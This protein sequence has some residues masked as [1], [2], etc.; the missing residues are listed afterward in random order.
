M[1]DEF[2][3]FETPKD[4]VGGLLGLEHGCLQVAGEG[5][6]PVAATALGLVE[7][8]VGI[9][10]DLRQVVGRLGLGCNADADADAAFLVLVANRNAHR[11]D[12]A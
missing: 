12:D 11:L 10:E 4:L 2:L 9:D 7:G 8:D 3:V 6:V 5:F 1:R